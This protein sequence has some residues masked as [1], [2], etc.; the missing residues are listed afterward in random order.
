M[1]IA[2]KIERYT[3]T[4]TARVESMLDAC[5]WIVARG[6]PGDFIECGVW[7]GGSMMALAYQ[8][9][10]LGETRRRLWLYDTFEGMTPPGERD[11]DWAGHRAETEMRHPKVAAVSPLPEVV[12]NMDRTGYPVENIVYV[13]GPVEQTIPAQMPEAIALLR[14]DTDWYTSTRHELEHLWPRLQPGGALIID[15]YGWWR[16]C[17]AA[18]DEWLEANGH[19][20]TLT[21][22]DDIGYIGFKP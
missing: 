16:G 11:V 18:V 3:M 2:A 7:R 9:I 21:N 4:S 22:I 14:L 10:A 12:A 6:V 8:L 13:V 1:S 20:L 5:R 19:P 15:D 17:R